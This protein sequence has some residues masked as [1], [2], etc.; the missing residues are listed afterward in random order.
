[1]ELVHV[2][3]GFFLHGDD[4]IFSSSMQLLGRTT[5]LVNP[6]PPNQHH[7]KKNMIMIMIIIMTAKHFHSQQRSCFNPYPVNVEN[8]V[9][10]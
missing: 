7:L 8:R 1:M 4:N 2:L 3:I 9:S 10:S 6:L 5:N